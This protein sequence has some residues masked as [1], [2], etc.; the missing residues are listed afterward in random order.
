M[1]LCDMVADKDETK[2]L[3]ATESE[4]KE[5]RNHEQITM[6][7]CFEIE[8][9][10]FKKMKELDGKAAKQAKPTVIAVGKRLTTWN[11]KYGTSIA[12]P[13]QQ[14]LPFAKLD[15]KEKRDV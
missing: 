2:M 15:K 5:V 14:A 4:R 6:V 8:D 9:R 11:K 12:S 10:A 1:K 7:M 13:T 3:F